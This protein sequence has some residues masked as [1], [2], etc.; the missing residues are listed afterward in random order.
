MC[1]TQLPTPQC[2][3]THIAVSNVTVGKM[4]MHGNSTGTRDRTIKHEHNT[5][6]MCS[7]VQER[8]LDNTLFK[9]SVA[10][11]NLEARGQ[12]SVQQLSE[13]VPNNIAIPTQ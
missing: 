1:L 7:I 4:M 10:A 9:A 2:A 13:P 5:G 12:D 3:I 8:K 6:S 11:E